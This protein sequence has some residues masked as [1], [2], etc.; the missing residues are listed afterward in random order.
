MTASEQTAPGETDADE[1]DA[2][3]AQEIEFDL[4]A[5]WTEDAVRELG[6]EYA[7]PA[8]CRGSGSPSDLAWLAEALVISRETRVV[9]VGSGVGGPA[10]WL[11]DHFGAQPVCVEPMRS[12]AAA[13]RRVFGLPTGVAGAGGLPPGGGGAAPVAPP[14][15]RRGRGGPA[16]AVRC[17]RRGAVPRRAVHGPAG[18]APGR[19]PG[20]AP[21]PAGRGRPGS[22]RLRRAGPA[23]RAAARGQRLPD[24]GG[25]DGAPRGRRVHGGAEH[26]VGRTRAGARGLAGAG[27]RRGRPAGP[28]PRRR[29]ALAAGAGADGTDLPADRRRS[30]PSAARPCPRRRVNAVGRIFVSYRRADDPF[31]AGLVAAVLRDRFGDDGVFLDT[32]VLNRR[33]NPE[34]GLCRG[35][36]GS[37]VVLALIGRRWEAR[38]TARDP[39]ATATE[40]DW[41]AWELQ[42]A[43]RRTLRVIPVFLRRSPLLGAGVPDD[44]SRI[45]PRE[46]AV[47]VRQGSL[48]SDTERL[49]EM[50]VAHSDGVT[51]SRT[52]GM[53]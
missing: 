47:A 25:A 3:A 50:V 36:D 38:L 37:A 44:L 34:S 26:G 42:E 31:G 12:A 49:V 30:R 52:A 19:R 28:P 16:A 23:A 15:G 43:A 41:V 14:P 5:S 7:I 40:R 22:A 27:R 1:T 39:G 20:T 46:T 35:L 45:L 9:D 4:L 17:V 51:S 48:R 13:G 2:D 11:A 6:P 21:G 33:G 29:S 32:W 8:G 53:T 18:A 24:R 10:G